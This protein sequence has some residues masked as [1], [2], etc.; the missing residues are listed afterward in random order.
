MTSLPRDLAAFVAAARVG[1]LA[2]VDQRGQPHIVPVCFVYSGGLI[3]SVLDAKPKR[4]PVAELRRV[5]NLLANHNVQLLV[6]H[7]DEDWSQLRY[8][9]LRGTASSLETGAEHDAAL[10]DLRAKYSQY[11]SMPIDGSPIIRIEVVRHVAWSATS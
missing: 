4:V 5:R 9:Q 7:Y 8:V 11:V 6:D 3:Y 10:A 1:R 2:T